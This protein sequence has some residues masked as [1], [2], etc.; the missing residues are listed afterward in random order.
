MHL[1]NSQFTLISILQC[2][3]TNEDFV[4]Q[5]T[6]CMAKQTLTS[7]LDQGIGLLRY[8]GHACLMRTIPATF[9]LTSLQHILTLTYVFV[10]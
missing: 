10:L 6:T 2:L 7:Y 4:T 1:Q 5:G 8:V 3:T 9:F